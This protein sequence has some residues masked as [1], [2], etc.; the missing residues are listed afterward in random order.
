M[1]TS[2]PLFGSW[3]TRRLVIFSLARILLA[4]VLVLG[5]YALLPDTP[6][7]ELGN[8]LIIVGGTSVFLLVLYW[9]VR[10]VTR[11]PRPVVRAIEALAI[12]VTLFLS[13]F[14]SQYVAESLA[15]G[16]AFSQPLDKF[17]ALYYT[18]TVFSTVGFGDI[19]PVSDVARALTMAPDDRQHHRAR[20]G[21]PD[22]DQR[23]PRRVGA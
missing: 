7:S 1:T 2:G 9:Q 23:R 6:N 14:A 17:S 19:T 16:S 8:W 10:E 18:T 3:P 20:C 4:I 5:L 12:C 22:P 11:S 13:L 15:D 21:L